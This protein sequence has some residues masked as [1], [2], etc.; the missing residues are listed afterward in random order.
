MCVKEVRRITVPPSLAFGAE[1]YKLVPP[2]SYVLFDVKLIT[3]NGVV[4]GDQNT[5]L[6]VETLNEGGFEECDN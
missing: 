2:D 6:M 1:G 4:V 5:E 3:I